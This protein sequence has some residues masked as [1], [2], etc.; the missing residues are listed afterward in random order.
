MLLVAGGVLNV[1]G[2]TIDKACDFLVG[3]LADHLTRCAHN[4]GAGRVDLAFGNERAGT[5]Q[6]MF[7]DH[8][9]VQYRGTNADQAAPADAATVQHDLVANRD[10]GFQRQGCARIRMKDAAILN[11]TAWTDDNR[12]VVASKNSIPPD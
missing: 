2:G 4:Q 3:E 11:I 1:A 6:A 9:M 10:I 5:D 8:G 7:T 12:L